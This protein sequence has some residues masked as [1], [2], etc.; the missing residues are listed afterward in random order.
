[1]F[2]GTTRTVLQQD[3][4]YVKGPK[5]RSQRAGICH[6]QNPKGSL[7]SIC[8]AKMSDVAAQSKQAQRRL[9]IRKGLSRPSLPKY[10]LNM[11]TLGRLMA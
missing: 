11:A 1:M 2:N 9:I 6:E 10:M 5:P 3:L 7:I 4:L 8:R